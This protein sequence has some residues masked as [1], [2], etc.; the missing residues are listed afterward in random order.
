MQ[1]LGENIELACT[2][3]FTCFQRITN[4]S[5]EQKQKTAKGMLTNDGYILAI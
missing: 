5:V 3:K 1:K 4:V 2:L